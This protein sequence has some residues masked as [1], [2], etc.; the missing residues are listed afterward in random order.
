M[1]VEENIDSVPDSLIDSANIS[2]SSLFKLL[3][4]DRDDLLGQLRRRVLRLKEI[5][6]EKSNRR[7]P[8]TPREN[9]CLRT[10]SHVLEED[11]Y[12][13]ANADDK[14][15]RILLAVKSHDD[16]S[17]GNISLFPK[18]E[19][20]PVVA[21]EE[22]KLET[23]MS[24]YVQKTHQEFTKDDFR[25]L[26]IADIIAAVD[27]E[28]GNP[29]ASKK[30]KR[31]PSRSKIS[32]KQARSAQPPSKKK[33]SNDEL[34]NFPPELMQYVRG[35]FNALRIILLN[36]ADPEEG[37]STEQICE[38]VRVWS[39]D[40][41]IRRINSQWISRVQFV[42]PALSLLAGK[43]STLVLASSPNFVRF[44]STTHSW[45]WLG[46]R[47]T[48]SLDDPVEATES[49][50][51][52]LARLFSLWARRNDLSSSG[53][54]SRR[55]RPKPSSRNNVEHDE[56]KVDDFSDNVGEQEASVGTATKSRRRQVK[57][58]QVPPPYFTTDWQCAL[59]TP[60]QR[61]QFQEQEEKRFSMPWAP[62]VYNHHGY[63]SVV[64]PVFRDGSG[65]RM[66]AA[67][68]ARDH[69][70]LRNDRPPWVSISEIVRDAVA[71]LP[72]GEGTRPEI[73]MLVQDSGSAL[74]R[75]QSEGENSPV[76]Y[77]SAQRLWI[78]RFRHLSANDF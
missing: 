56:D 11:D 40:H 5:V 66:R 75:L 67:L 50:T 30:N 53:G 37:I 16:K 38:I 12:L 59:S 14:M 1:M 25:N 61:R 76:M 35:F 77:D 34:C 13:K 39:S 46:Y 57:L 69:P 71:R 29:K 3:N 10:Y 55:Q 32:A 62:F 20:Q 22:L 49:E 72:N 48:T 7:I 78:Y 36:M 52:I 27:T 64:A 65:N 74:D 51:A 24:D 54:D 23:L 9:A 47:D 70:L 4:N 41:R 58:E 28:S 42:R 21:D 19:E 33:K 43:N 73:A 8:I 2:F 26:R 18:D 17:L 68:S 45:H 6:D 31:K 44:D 63:A 15:N 60:E